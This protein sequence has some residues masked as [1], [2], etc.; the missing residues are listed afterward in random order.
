MARYLIEVSGTL[1]PILFVLALLAALIG[2]PYAHVNRKRF[3]AGIGVG[4]LA[5]CLMVLLQKTTGAVIRELYN[6][7]ILLFSLLCT[8][9]LC[10]RPAAA[11][12]ATPLRQNMLFVCG[13][14]WAAFY[15][16]DLFLYPFDF[17][18]DTD[19]LFC[20]CVLE[21]SLAYLIALCL[22]S[23]G[24]LALSRL[25]AHFRVESRK[26]ICLLAL[27]IM[28][29]QQLVLLLQIAF[30]RHWVPAFPWIFEGLVFLLQYQAFFLF[31]QL[32]L[33]ACIAIAGIR[34]YWGGGRRGPADALPRN[35]AEVRK[36]RAAAR[37]KVA[38]GVLAL[39]LT[40]LVTLI[41]TLGKRWH[42]QPVV[43]S[44]PTAV[45][46]QEGQ[47]LVPVAT[48]NDGHLHRF[49]YTAKDGTPVRF[50]IIRKNDSAYGVGLDA[51]DVCGP[52][53][54]YER[55]GKVVCILCDVVINLSTIGLKGGCN[56]VPLAHA[57]QSASLVIQQADL[58]KEAHRFRDGG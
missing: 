11:N 37:R 20:F 54:Y 8:G 43:L 24:A 50:I 41:L 34:V 22:T 53:G 35:P 45:L 46:P 17:T 15:F 21:K 19:T 3:F 51:C 55:D 16:P 18:E 25:A 26:K 49:V 28:A 1:V 38:W 32:G 23:V 42:E 47:I 4:L 39:C 6:A 5:A 12:S 57:L 14:L 52:S 7:P 33:S 56:P 2:E 36:Y 40:V 29:L 58:E 27:G 31:A 13:A 44:P 9:F 48:V 10:L 30:S